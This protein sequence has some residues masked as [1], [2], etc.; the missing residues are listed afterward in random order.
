[1]NKGKMK[2]TIFILV[3]LVVAAAIAAIA[4]G[5]SVKKGGENTAQTQE[6][7]QTSETQQPAQ[8]TAA[9]T[10]TE[11]PSPSPSETEQPSETPAETQTPTP[12]KTV[13]RT[14]SGSGS[15][16]SNTGTNL[17]L[18]VKYSAAA[19][20]DTE[21]SITF[22]MYLNCYTINATAKPGGASVT[23]N[24]QTY[25][26]STPDISSSS[27]TP[28]SVKLCSK[29]V[30]VPL[31]AGESLSVPIS[32]SWAF[33]GKYSDVDMTTIDAAGTLNVQG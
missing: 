1:M 13:T 23:F 27:S 8:E 33:G 29:T 14:V 4:T 30:T 10:E 26:M 2:A 7:A 21:A 17:N 5:R 18:V 24:G 12:T 9:E 3:L 16:S 15:F 31:A 6:S 32:A 25:T 28:T 20:S 19:K 22:T 11:S